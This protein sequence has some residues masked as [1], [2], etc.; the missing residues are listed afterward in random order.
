[1]CDLHHVCFRFLGSYCFDQPC[2]RL[3]CV[4]TDLGSLDQDSG[5]RPRG[6]Q[7]LLPLGILFCVADFKKNCGTV[8]EPGYHPAR[9]CRRSQ[10]LLLR[11]VSIR[12]SAMVKSDRF[13][14]S[15]HFMLAEGILGDYT[16]FIETVRRG[17]PCAASTPVTWTSTPIC[18]YG[19]ARFE[20]AWRFSSTDWRSASPARRLESFLEPQALAREKET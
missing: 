5:A 7:T 10:R 6:L 11:W 18:V 9:V 8:M 2:S 19:S 13:W 20:I 1:M 3:F 14:S 17:L 16:E 4:P 12:V 15:Q